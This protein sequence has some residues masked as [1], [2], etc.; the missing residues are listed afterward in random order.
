MGNANYSLLTGNSNNKIKSFYVSE[1][2][3][4][5]KLNDTKVQDLKWTQVT[6]DHLL[7]D[8]KWLYD[9]YVDLQE[10][11]ENDEVIEVNLISLTVPCFKFIF[12]HT[13]NFSV[14]K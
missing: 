14:I 13:N 11:N 9:N 3:P 4:Q 6:D 8:N 12:K 2:L 5:N 7:H 10:E 1:D